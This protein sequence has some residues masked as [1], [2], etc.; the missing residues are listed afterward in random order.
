MSETE[1]LYPESVKDKICQLLMQGRSIR[2][3]CENEPGMPHESTVRLWASKLNTE[4]ST[5]Y[6]RARDIQADCYA[7]EIIDIAD[8]STQETSSADRLKFDARRWYV[9]KV[10]PKKYGD[11]LDLTSAGEKIGNDLSGF[12]S[13]Q[14]AQLEVIL[15]TQNPKT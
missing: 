7:D 14:L 8:K 2:S 9:S 12:S 11:K 4:F 10:L 13:D 1:S 6:R 3:I 5:Q 15:S